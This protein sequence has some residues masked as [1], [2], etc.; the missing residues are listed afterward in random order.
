MLFNRA[1]L[2]AL[3]TGFRTVFNDAFTA[4]PSVYDR[5]AMVVPS[6]TAQEVYPW[7]GNTSQFREWLGDRVIQNLGTHQFTIRNRS[8]E[9]TVG[10]DRDHIDDD[11][12]GIYRPLIAQLGQS[13]KTHPDELVFALL[14]AGFAGLCYDGQYF[15]DT[16]HPVAGGSVSNYQAGGGTPWFL[17]DCSRA[18]RPII[19]QRRRDYTFVAMDQPS[20]EQVF[21]CKQIRYGVDAR[22]NAGYGLWQMAYASKADLTAD[23][24]EAAIAAMG[25][26]KAENGKP[27]A[28]KPTLLVV[29]PTLGAAARKLIKA[30]IV[31]GTTNTNR[32]VVEVLETPWLA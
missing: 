21:S 5:V 28:I 25:S 32:D 1:S 22:A 18:I 26:L 2:S 14:K 3:T 16:D 27:L 11:Q 31:D 20:D 7:L 30:E 10:V 8:F 19:F 13:A 24:L 15:F 29:P 4:A 9:S 12:L 17:L 6:T 23:N